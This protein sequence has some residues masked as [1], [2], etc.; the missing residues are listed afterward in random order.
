MDEFEDDIPDIDWEAVFNRTE[1]IPPVEN[2]TEAEPAF[3]NIQDCIDYGRSQGMDNLEI[4]E[5]CGL[6]H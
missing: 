1:P 3:T 6:P 2:V 5:L 4:R